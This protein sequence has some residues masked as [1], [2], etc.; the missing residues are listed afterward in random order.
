MG[1]NVHLRLRFVGSRVDGEEGRRF[2]A[3]M[4][5]GDDWMAMDLCGADLWM[6]GLRMLRGG[7]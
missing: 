2:D 3:V 1:R 5:G 6:G 4:R 7:S